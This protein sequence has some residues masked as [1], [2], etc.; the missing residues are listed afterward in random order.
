MIGVVLAPAGLLVGLVAAGPWLW[1]AGAGW[2]LAM[3][4]TGILNVIGVSMRQRETPEAL[5]G[6]MNAT[7]RFMS[8]GA[9]AAGC[10][11]LRPD[12]PVRERSR[13]DVGGRRLPGGRL[14]AGAAYLRTR[15][16]SGR[17]VSRAAGRGRGRGRRPDWMT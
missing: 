7:F 5:L 4:K 3:F 2:S 16:T 17:G 14:R 15:P 12:R 6:R 11:R 9:L 8:T 1:L 10:G 13:R